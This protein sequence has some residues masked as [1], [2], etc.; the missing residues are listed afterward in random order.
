LRSKLSRLRPTPG[1]VL[2]AVAVF[3]AIG[4]IGYA[5]ATIG[6]GDIKNGAVTKAKLHKNAVVS[7]KVKNHSLLCK[8]LK[9]GCVQGPRGARGATGPAGPAG[10]AGGATG[11]QGPPG[12]GQAF[13]FSLENN[14]TSTINGGVWSVRF[15]GSGAGNCDQVVVTNLG[16]TAGLLARTNM[17]NGGTDPFD[18]GAAGSGTNTVTFN[19]DNNT[20][21]EL[22]M[23]SS[24]G[25]KEVTFYNL[26]NSPLCTIVGAD[27]HTP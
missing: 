1:V 6:T 16:S 25:V 12:P 3:F 27:I 9:N 14:N 19:P 8:D 2:G 7:K 18:V 11:P 23:V 17:T 21:Y 15:R 22:D 10:P 13:G 26:N 5:A 20:K 4:S 24:Q